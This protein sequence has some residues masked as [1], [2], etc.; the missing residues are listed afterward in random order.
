MLSDTSW[1]LCIDGWISLLSCIEHLRAPARPS[2][3]Q[4]KA[5]GTACPN[6][7]EFYEKGLSRGPT[8]RSLSKVNTKS[9]NLR[10]GLQR[11]QFLRG[12]FL[13]MIKARHVWLKH[14]AKAKLTL[15]SLLNWRPIAVNIQSATAESPHSGL[16][17]IFVRFGS[18]L[19]VASW[20]SSLDITFPTTP[21]SKSA[22][23]SI[24][25]RN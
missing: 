15:H 18:R 19:F 11:Y 7:T 8:S 12:N 6:N 5:P 13:R 3:G 24:G 9:Y 22:L 25:T 14:V 17:R 23:L 21:L 2:L 1:H 20:S 16:Q 10:M 4:P